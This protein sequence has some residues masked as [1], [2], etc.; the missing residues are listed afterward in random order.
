M[1]RLSI[2][3]KVNN[4]RVV[5]LWIINRL[6]PT[7]NLR[8]RLTLNSDSSLSASSFSTYSE[9]SRFQDQCVPEIRNCRQI[10]QEEA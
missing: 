3:E 4:M 7:W 5:I 10:P 6:A 2:Q 8:P 9:E 1:R